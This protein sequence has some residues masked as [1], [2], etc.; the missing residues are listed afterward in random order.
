MLCAWSDHECF[1][2]RW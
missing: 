1:S 2:D